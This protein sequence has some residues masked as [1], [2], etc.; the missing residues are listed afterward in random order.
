MRDQF[1]CAAFFFV[2]GFG[3]K[4]SLTRVPYN[5]I[6]VATAISCSL[7]EFNLMAQPTFVAGRLAA[8]SRYVGVLCAVLPLIAPSVAHSQPA[9]AKQSAKIEY[10]Q[11]KE[12]GSFA[13]VNG[14]KLYV[15]TYGTGQPLLLIHG[16]GGSIANMSNQIA[17]FSPHYRVIAADSR[18]HGKS[19]MGSGRLTY[20]QMAEDLNSM[21]DAR[22]VKSVYILGWSDGGILGLLMAIHHPE[23]VVKLAIMGANLQPSGAYDWALDW[24]EKNNKL[25]DQMLAKGDKSQPWSVYKQY[26]DLL[27]KQPNIP[28]TDLSKITAATLVMAG[29][30][31]VVRGEHTLQIFENIPRAQLCIFPGATHMI[32]QANSAEF[33]RTV[34]AFFDKPFS[35]P[36]TKDIFK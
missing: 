23:R 4:E 3:C 29:D 20:E 11:N 18:G 2:H 31:D 33:N 34:A 32:P 21:L 28:L 25:V 12:A 24:V 16:N 30:K 19:E 5:G 27:G 15:E 8:A 26:L 22:G 9:S 10:G 35:R 13:S 36:D 7:E 6:G 14:I 1:S 17:Y